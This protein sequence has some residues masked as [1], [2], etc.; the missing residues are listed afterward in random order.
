[1][2][3][4][5]EPEIKNLTGYKTKERQRAWLQAE[6]IPFRAD[7]HGRIIVASEH[8]QQWVRG[9]ELRPSSGP[10]MDMVA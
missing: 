6:G 8:V 4:L 5:T 7:Q 10:R 1:V 9:I 2:I 3:T